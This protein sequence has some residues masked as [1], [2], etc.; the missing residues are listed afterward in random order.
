[1]GPGP[2]GLRN[3]THTLTAQFVPIKHSLGISCDD[4]SKWLS[5][6]F[7]A[8]DASVYI[9]AVVSGGT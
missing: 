6:Y 1:M 5:S 9:L 4:A 8:D 2:L 7:K 3:T